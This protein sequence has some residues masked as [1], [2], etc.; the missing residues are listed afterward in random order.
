MC[1][2]TNLIFTTQNFS[3]PPFPENNKKLI[4]VYI[5]LIYVYTCEANIWTAFLIHFLLNALTYTS[6][7]IYT[8]IVCSNICKTIQHKQMLFIYMLL[9]VAI[10]LK[11]LIYHELYCCYVLATSDILLHVEGIF[12]GPALIAR[13]CSRDYIVLDMESRSFT[14]VL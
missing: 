14:F 1:Q 13:Q 10:Q 5:K 9:T 12:Q 4:C 2:K 6:L 8:S 7:Y 11:C 3:W